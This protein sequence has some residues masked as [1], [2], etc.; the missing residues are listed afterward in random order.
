M[1]YN[2]PMMT[3][4][5]LAVLLAHVPADQKRSLFRSFRTPDQSLTRGGWGAGN[6]ALRRQF[7]NDPE[8]RLERG[9]QCAVC[10]EYGGECSYY[11]YEEARM[12]DHRARRGVKKVRGSH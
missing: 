12:D 4:K 3:R 8:F 2:L 5:S 7:A 11:M 10:W 9:C 6:R 1:T